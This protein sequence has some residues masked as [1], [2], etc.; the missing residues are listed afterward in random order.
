MASTPSHSLKLLNALSIR[1]QGLLG[2]EN[3]HQSILNILK[4]ELRFEGIQFWSLPAGVASNARLDAVVGREAGMIELG[5]ALSPRDTVL[6][7]VFQKKQ[8]LLLET[9]PAEVKASSP[10][11]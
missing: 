1:L 5:H 8:A 2:S 11:V 9:I 7:Y 10:I 4:S 6:A 3:F